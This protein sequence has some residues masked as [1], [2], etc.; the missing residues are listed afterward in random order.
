[1]ARL[2][3]PLVLFG[4]DSSPFTQKVRLVL[5]LKQIRFSQPNLSLL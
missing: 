4:Y 3:A 5:K 1:M 2:I